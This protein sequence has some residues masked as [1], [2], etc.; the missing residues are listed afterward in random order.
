MWIEAKVVEHKF[1]RGGV[2]IIDAIPKK[3]SL[4]DDIYCGCRAITTV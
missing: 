3:L 1:L 4:F 2:V